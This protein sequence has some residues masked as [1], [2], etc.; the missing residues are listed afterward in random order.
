MIIPTQLCGLIVEDND[1]SRS[2]AAG[3]LKKLGI[4]TVLEAP[5]G[6][7]GLQLLHGQS[8]DFVLLDWYMPEINGTGFIRLAREGQVNCPKDIPII[9]STAYAT[10][11]NI[12][13]IQELGV[14]EIL[15]KPFDAKQLSSAISSALSKVATGIS[16]DEPEDDAD[17]EQILL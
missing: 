14:K 2:L 9:I 12:T 6:A 11:E 1:Y 8:I 5:D 17:D 13:R 15:I 16:N 10:R 3:C 7:A 4:G